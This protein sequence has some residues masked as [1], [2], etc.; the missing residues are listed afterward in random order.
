MI[1]RLMPKVDYGFDQWSVVSFVIKKHLVYLF[2]VKQCIYLVIS[3][4]SCKH[5]FTFCD[6]GINLQIFS[7]FWIFCWPYI[8][9]ELKRKGKFWEGSK[10]LDQT[11]FETNDSSLTISSNLLYFKFSKSRYRTLEIM[12]VSILRR[13]KVDIALASYVM[14]PL[15]STYL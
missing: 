14:K 12:N 9:R 10:S 7:Y 2:M 3:C 1:H 4:T 8:Q 6:L 13:N 11:Q 5:I 15:K